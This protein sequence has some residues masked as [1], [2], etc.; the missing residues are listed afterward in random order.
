VTTL[1]GLAI[2]TAALIAACLFPNFAGAQTAP[3]KQDEKRKSVPAPR[4]DLSGIW[5][6][7][8]ALDGIQPNGALSM[9]ADGKPEHE[10]HYTPLGSEMLKSHKSANGPNQ[11]APSDENDPAHICDPQGFPRENRFTCTFLVETHST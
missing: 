1:Q 4:R 11:V 10:L 5:E 9:P 8:K 6:P 2:L 3:P 7:V